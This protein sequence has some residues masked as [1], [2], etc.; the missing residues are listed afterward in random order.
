M[1]D[2]KKRRQKSN[3]ASRSAYSKPVYS[4]KYYKDLYKLYAMLE[5]L[6]GI[7][8]T[9]FEL[10]N[11]AFDYYRPIFEDKY[12]DYNR[13]FKDIESLMLIS[14]RYKKLSVFLSDMT[15]EPI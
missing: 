1:S 9:P 4:K 7:N 8:L 5:K 12:D 6:A 3:Y 2:Y 13:R 11:I 15:I 14:Q 10:I